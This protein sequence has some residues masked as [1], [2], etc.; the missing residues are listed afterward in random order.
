MRFPKR[1]RSSSGERLK[2]SQSPA[3]ATV[4]SLWCWRAYLA[5]GW[6][7]ARPLAACRRSDCCGHSG[8][9]ENEAEFRAKVLEH[10]EHQREKSALGRRKVHVSR[11]RHRVFLRA[12]SSMPRASNPIRRPDMAAS[13]SRT[14]ATDT[15]ILCCARKTA[16]T[17][18]TAPG[19]SSP[20]PFQSSSP[21]SSG[22]APSAR[23]RIAGPMRGRQLPGPCSHPANLM[24]RTGELFTKRMPMI[25]S[26]SAR[27]RAVIEMG[28]L[29][30][31]RRRAAAATPEPK[32]AAFSFLLTDTSSAAS[33]SSS[34]HPATLSTR[35]RPASSAGSARPRRDD[36][37]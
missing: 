24:R 19:R 15:S 2:V 34:I 17:K 6:Q 9:L 12:R 22:A 31:S 10:A 7:I 25:G 37:P 4:P 35:G 13:S 33:A 3:S 16:G 14:S 32:S 20:S 23:S 11:K 30:A 8:S 28:S 29:N 27:S 36:P 1:Q 18:R 5:T 21:G 26:W